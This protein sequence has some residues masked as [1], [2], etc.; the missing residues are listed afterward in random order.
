MLCVGK[1][2]NKFKTSVTVKPLALAKSESRPSLLSHLE[3][4]PGFHEEKSI[5]KGHGVETELTEECLP[6]IT[7]ILSPGLKGRKGRKGKHH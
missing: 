4:L 3:L 6:A 1:Y 2:R 7:C 5:C